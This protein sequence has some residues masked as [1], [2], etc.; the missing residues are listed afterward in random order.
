MENIIGILLPL[1]SMTTWHYLLLK[2]WNVRIFCIFS[3]TFASPSFAENKNFLTYL[4][5][6]YFDFFQE[7]ARARQTQQQMYPGMYQSA[8]GARPAGQVTQQ[9]LSQQAQQLQLLQ[10]MAQLRRA[11]EIQAQ[12]ARLAQLKQNQ[13]KNPSTSQ[14]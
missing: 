12:Q 11:Q 10:K 14:L 3:L 9:D 8:R 6:F 7:M 2:I 4:L 1:T 5:I 13:M